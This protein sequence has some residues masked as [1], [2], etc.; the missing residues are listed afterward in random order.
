M[1]NCAIYVRII[2]SE[3][4]TMQENGQE[5]DQEMS[6]QLSSL[7]QCVPTAAPD[8][9]S[10]LMYFSIAQ[11]MHQ[12]LMFL[13]FKLLNMVVKCVFKLLMTFYNLRHFSRFFLQEIDLSIYYIHT[14]LS[15]LCR[16]L[17]MK[18]PGAQHFPKHSKQPVW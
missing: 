12:D 18:I 1:C 14:I 10:W 15:T 11:Y 16:L 8:S 2:M 5:T 17:Y 3:T 7:V 4:K 6:K 9:C 13:H